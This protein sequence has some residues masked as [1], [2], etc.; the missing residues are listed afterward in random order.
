M[1]QIGGVAQAG[2][3]LQGTWDNIGQKTE[4]LANQLTSGDISDGAFVETFVQLKTLKLQADASM[5]VFKTLNDM[6][7]E[8]LSSPR[9]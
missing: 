6:A 2:L 8:L 1:S 7:G 5:L 4:E 9:K 3:S